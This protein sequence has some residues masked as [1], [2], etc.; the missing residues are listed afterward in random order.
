MAAKLKALD[1]MLLHL[2]GATYSEIAIECGYQTASGAWQAV[3]RVRDREAEWARYEMRT[4]HRVR[5]RH[6]PS[7]HDLEQAEV[8]I[9]E[10][11]ET[12][13]L[14][15]K[16]LEDAAERLQRWLVQGVK[17]RKRPLLEAATPRAPAT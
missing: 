1:A 10:E 5:A 3:Q 16:R 7:Q 8:R 14:D 12:G 11:M 17:R 9:R 13:G 15:G 2:A 4:G 6:R